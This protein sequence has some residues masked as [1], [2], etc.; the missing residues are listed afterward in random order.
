MMGF[1]PKS[2][3]EEYEI[4]EEQYNEIPQATSLP[5]S[6]RLSQEGQ[7]I[8]SSVLSLNIDW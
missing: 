5:G 8:I 4:A 7:R 1:L 6:S 2:S 3:R